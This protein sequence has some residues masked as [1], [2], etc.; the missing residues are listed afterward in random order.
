MEADCQPHEIQFR[1]L[2]QVITNRSIGRTYR[3][4]LQAKTPL[5]FLYSV[6]ANQSLVSRLKC[7]KELSFHRGCVNTGKCN[8]KLLRNSEL[9]PLW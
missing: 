7:Q 6:Q 2:H 3:H 5:S 9:V 1:N 8:L 4:N